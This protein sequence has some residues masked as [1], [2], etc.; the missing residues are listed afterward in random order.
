MR[1]IINGKRYDTDKAIE[2]GYYNNIG[3]SASS[4]SDFS[5][6]EAT[7]YKT[8]RSQSY[9][10]AGRGGPM[11]RFSQSC[12]QNQWSGGSDLIPMSKTEAMEWAET[13]LGVD[14]IEKHFDDMIEDA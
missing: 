12:G 5:W 7:L 4:S 11:S 13:H 9:F 2:I 14:A 8:P 6:W 10:I 1:K 3:D